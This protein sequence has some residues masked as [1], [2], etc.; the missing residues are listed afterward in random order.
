MATTDPLV[1]NALD[2]MAQK[3]GVSREDA[4]K[5]VVGKGMQQLG[6]QAFTQ[7]SNAV[8]SPTPMPG[9]GLTAHEA[10]HVI[11]QAT[12]RIKQL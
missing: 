10:T 11:Q 12:G 3:L 5:I 8:F 7:G 2:V 6:A 9:Q 4:L 1:N